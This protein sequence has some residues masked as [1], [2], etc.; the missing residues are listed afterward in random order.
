MYILLLTIAAE[1]MLDA[2]QETSDGSDVR[3]SLEVPWQSMSVHEA[4][5]GDDTNV[6]PLSEDI[7]KRCLKIP[8]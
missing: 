1:L 2:C 7:E 6:H 4:I 8:F 5:A 3:L